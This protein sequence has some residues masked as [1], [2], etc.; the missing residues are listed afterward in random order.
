MIYTGKYKETPKTKKQ[1]LF[2]YLVIKNVSA[3]TWNLVGPLKSFLKYVYLLIL[4]AFCPF[5]AF[6]QDR[7]GTVEYIARLKEQKLLLENSVQFE[8]WLLQKQTD[9]LRRNGALRTSATYQIPVVVH[10]IHNGEA[11]GSGKNIS[12]AQIASQLSVL[13]KDYKRLN[14]DAVNTPAEFQPIAG[15]F[16]VEFVLAKQNP[17]GL[18]T[19]GI[20]RVQGTKTSWTM[21]DNYELK[22]LSY[23]PAE[24]YL[25]I[26]VCNM[27][28]FLGYAQFPVSGLPG[29][30]N[31][32]ANRLTDGVVIA[33]DAFGSSDDG[34]FSLQSNYDKGR[35]ATHEIG[36]FFG[37]IHIWGDDD[38]ACNGT[39]NVN[40]TPNQGGS[41]SGC[42]AHPRATC[43][44]V[45]SMFQNYLDYTND[46][47]MNLFTQGQ[48]ERMITIIENSPRR[49]SL[50]NSPALSDPLPLANDLGIKDIITP[51]AGECSAMFIPA[52]EIRNYGSNIIS[53]ARIRVKKDGVEAETKDFNFSPALALLGSTTVTFSELSFSTGN[54]NVT[55][56]ILLTNG[57]PDASAPNNVLAQD[58]FIPQ[59]IGIPFLETLNSIPPSWSI[60]NPD[61]NTTWELANAPTNQPNTALKMG[62]Y[63]YEDHTGEVDLAVTPVFDL[64]SAPA[65]LLKFDVAYSRFQSSN[66][67]LK[68]VLLNNCNTDIG[69]GVVV[70]NKSGASLATTTASSSEFTPGSAA[71]WRNEA[72]DLT[73]YIGQNNLQLAFVGYNDWGN[74]LYLDNI[75]LTTSPIHDVTLKG[76]IAPSP[77]SCQNQVP[78]ILRIQNA[79]TL[80]TSL[81]V[82]SIINGQSSTQ[83]FTGLSLSGNT[84][85][86]LNLAPINLAD[87][88]N[89]ISFE[90]TEPNGVDD[91]NPAD[92][93]RA[94]RII[95]NKSVDE[96]PLRENFENDIETQWT[97]V[98]PTDGMSW[99]TTTVGTTTAL[100]FNA[101][102][103]TLF[104]D[105][106]WFVSPVLDFSRAEQASLSYDLSYAYRSNTSD[107]LYILASKDC[108]YTFNDTLSLKSGSELSDGKN[109][110]T[111][112]EPQN[113]ADWVNKSLDLSALAGEQNVRI[114]FVFVND[115]GNN[116]YLDN[117][118]FFVSDA[119]LRLEETFAI[120][121]NPVPDGM[122]NIAFNL[123]QKDA[124]TV[125][126][127]DSMGK[128]LLTETLEDVLNQTFP[129]SL[130]GRS[131]GV[132]LVRIKTGG[133]VFMKKIIVLK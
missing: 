96:I 81:K 45:T 106:S 26:W 104:G 98:N 91:F 48:V 40:D 86:E 54:H 65:A 102:D 127:L 60:I 107:K 73:L 85:T 66:D 112:W 123:P 15:V 28:D 132:Y 93:Q 124:V 56:E 130:E 88:E 30:E 94:M 80:I 50:T 29:L 1:L 44:G 22:S 115:S 133:Q 2:L 35:T 32:S 36:H 12:D 103:N 87:G 6:P 101:F 52:L 120:Y 13:N 10:V 78:P 59:A 23:W 39:D 122:A 113:E 77:V 95:V 57:V 61:Q 118:E 19:N 116:L 42:P 75:S 68:V 16:D 90:L 100:Y 4:L 126:I 70:Y 79:G 14:A 110:T 18:S 129:L 47:C 17:E 114:A 84:E 63:N 41:T 82:V 49:A 20:V 92:N 24:D 55:F 99:E 37:L 64:S 121:P 31:S 33:F 53:N 89:Q 5:A 25:N 62:F 111:S 74:N 76:V 69:Q 117:I 3:S 51:D 131:S 8:R 38:G 9:K 7:C 108:G 125:D 21:N 105:E 27:S 72:V 71:E 83:T 58:V 11:I 119:P 43:T 97:T 67:G 128:I 109:S 34:A 46:D